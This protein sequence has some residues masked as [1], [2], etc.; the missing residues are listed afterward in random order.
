VLVDDFRCTDRAGIV[1]YVHMAGIESRS[2]AMSSI[3][4]SW[5]ELEEV[6]WEEVPGREDTWNQQA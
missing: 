5:A 1:L 3:M 4:T 6:G 2:P